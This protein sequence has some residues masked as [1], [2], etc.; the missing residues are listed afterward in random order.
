M[1]SDAGDP[2]NEDWEPPPYQPEWETEFRESTFNPRKMQLVCLISAVYFT[3]HF[4]GTVVVRADDEVGGGW[5]WQLATWVPEILCAT[6]NLLWMAVLGARATRG[7]C[8]RHYSLVSTYIIVSSYA[9][10][11]VPSF[12][13]EYRLARFH[14]PHSSNLWL[15]IDYSSFPPVRACVYLQDA[16]PGFVATCTSVLSG[17]SFIGY[18]FWNLLP[19]ICRV[20]HGYAVFVAVMTG[21]MLL[22]LTLAIGVDT[23]TMVACVAFQL[24]AGLGAGVFCVLG[25]RVSR[26]KYAILKSTQFSGVQ[27][28]DLLYT[29]IP[30]NVVANIAEHDPAAMLGRE[31]PHCVIMFCSLEPHADLR[32]SEAALGLLDCIFSAFDEAVARHAVFKYQH[33]G[34]WYIV[35]CPRAANPFDAAEQSGPADRDVRSIVLLGLELQGIAASRFRSLSGAAMWLRV[36]VACGPAAGAVIGSLRS[37]YCIYGDT[38]NTAARMCIH[39][40]P[41]SIHCTQEFAGLVNPAGCLVRVE[42]LGFTEVKGKGPMHTYR[43][44]PEATPG[45]LGMVQLVMAHIE[46]PQPQSVFTSLRTIVQ[47]SAGQVHA[48]QW[49]RSPSRQIDRLTATFREGA[50]EAQFNALMLTGHRRLLTAGLMLHALCIP[51]QWRLAGVGESPPPDTTTFAS[52]RTNHD[53][54]MARVLFTV[55]WI[56]SWGASL[57]LLCII[58]SDITHTRRAGTGFQMLLIGHLVVQAVAS[59]FMALGGDPWSWTL[60]FGTGA[61]LVCGW[62]GPTSVPSA[63]ALSLSAAVAFYAALPPQERYATEA[64]MILALAIGLVL[65]VW[66]NNRD[67]R[68]RFLLRELCKAQLT[69]L[70]AILHDLLPPSIARTMIRISSRPRPES[71]RAAVLQLDICKFTV[72]AQTLAPLDLARLIHRL[73]Q[74]FDAEVQRQKL[75]KMDTIGDAYIV[76][77]LLPDT[78]AR[79]STQRVCHGLVEVARVMIQT[80]EKH[81]AETGQQVACRIG[82]AVGTV[83][84]AVLGKLQ[85]RFHIQGPGVCTAEAL[86]AGSPVRNALHASEP[87]LRAARPE[88]VQELCPVGWRVHSTVDGIDGPSYCLVLDEHHGAA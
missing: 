78:Y 84:T 31:I 7:F 8:I 68:N 17:K 29:L 3:G 23:W 48:E 35:A 2:D 69:H 19:R 75:F 32:N 13:W 64:A 76:A 88:G 52:L 71:C 49:L 77:G 74:R 45:R 1:P 39:A 55:H 44:V 86:E 54:V 66:V 51:L 57:G 65:L 38:V 58:W 73:F 87:F 22:F 11:I 18:L 16:E 83:V 43:L 80:L 20:W 61:C 26:A 37:F 27:N 28:R 10:T 15:S 53:R 59:N 9:A 14:S 67:Q 4:L 85:P 60:V 12:L 24:A 41:G 79:I 70:R 40:S 6:Q 47:T 30:P 33:V 82:V 34:D 46:P 42:D 5:R 63:S 62:L 81:T 25:E 50:I 36:G 72:L 56:V 21:S